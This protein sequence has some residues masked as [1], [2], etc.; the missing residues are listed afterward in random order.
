ML[1]PVMATGTFLQHEEQWLLH[2][3]FITSAD[4]LDASWIRETD[5]LCSN[6]LLVPVTASGDFVAMATAYFIVAACK[7][8]ASGK[9]SVTS[10]MALAS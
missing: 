9:T 5:L 2:Y 4:V 6:T 3:L 1:V 8:D 7:A 10:P